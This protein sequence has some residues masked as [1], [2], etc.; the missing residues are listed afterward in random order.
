MTQGLLEEAGKLRSADV[1][2]FDGDVT[3]AYRTRP[4]FVPALMETCLPGKASELRT[5]LKSAIL[6]FEIKT[7]HP[8]AD[9]NGRWDGSVNTAAAKW[10]CLCRIPM[11][12][13]S[14]TGG[15]L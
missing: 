15:I 8:F 10:N 11:G 4:Q 1:G 14:K 13:L 3:S 2:V 7:I 12:V 9:G 5:V 6:H